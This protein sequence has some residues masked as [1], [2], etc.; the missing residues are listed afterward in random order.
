MKFKKFLTLAFLLGSLLV[1]SLILIEHASKNLGVEDSSALFGGKLESGYL[2]AGYLIAVEPDSK[3]TT[4]GVAFIDDST[5]V[6]AAH[7]IIK[8]AAHY[9]GTGEFKLSLRNNFEV[10]YAEQNPQ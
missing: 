4:C 9:L 8:G 1:M 2:Y 5:A 10:L 3:V 6:T 7:C